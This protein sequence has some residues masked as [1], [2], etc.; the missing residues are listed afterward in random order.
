VNHKGFRGVALIRSC[1]VMGAEM[2]TMMKTVFG[3]TERTKFMSVTVYGCAVSCLK[4]SP[5][6]ECINTT[7]QNPPSSQRE[8]GDDVS[9]I[10]TSLSRVTACFATGTRCPP[11]V[12]EPGLHLRTTKV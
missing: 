8:T 1:E 4:K 3:G 11:T 12:G 5:R 7:K 9:P 10:T 2:H 6:R